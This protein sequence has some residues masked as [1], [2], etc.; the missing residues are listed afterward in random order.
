MFNNLDKAKLREWLSI[1]VEKLEDHPDRRMDVAIKDTPD[2]ANLMYARMMA[3]EVLKNNEEGKPTRWVLCCGPFAPVAEFVK[4]VNKERIPLKNVHIFHMDEWC[5]W[6]GFPVPVDNP[7]SMEGQM[8]RDFYGEIDPALVLPEEQ[9]HF[10][11]IDDLGA[12]MREIDKLGGLDTVWA[13]LGMCGHIAFNEPPKFRY[14][15]VSNEDMLNATMHIVPLNDDTIINAGYRYRGSCMFAVPPMGITIGF[16][17]MMRA[18]RCVM[19]STSGAWKHT[20]MRIALFSEPT[21]DF[22][23]TLLQLMETRPLIIVDKNTI[24]PVEWI[25]N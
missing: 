17:E 16:K 18:H 5:D 6:K 7:W 23:G 13:G 9:R 24:Q 20:I 22:P 4:I 1:P 10:P 14:A 12:Y 2:E 8:R 15:A 19:I 21:V 3:D 25:D 11:R